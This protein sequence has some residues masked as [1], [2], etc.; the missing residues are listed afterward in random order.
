[1]KQ[2]TKRALAW[3]LAAVMTFA[4]LPALA[5][6]KQT[7]A[8][9]QASG[10]SVKVAVH[11]KATPTPKAKVTVATKQPAASGGVVMVVS[12]WNGGKLNL[13]EYPDINSAC[14]GQY[15][16]GTLVT[17]YGISYGWAHVKV[18]GMWGYMMAI[19][20]ADYS[21]PVKPPKPQSTPDMT[22]AKKYVVS[23]GND[24]KLHLRE[25]ASTRAPSL[26]LFPNG[27]KVKGIDLGN[28]WVLVK[29]NGLYGYMMRKFLVRD[30]GK[31]PTPT[32][33]PKPGGKYQDMQ[34]WTGNS[35]KLHLREAP[36]TLARSLGLYPN[37]T[38][39]K[40]RSVG[41]GWSQVKVAGV[42]GYMM[43][44]YLIPA[45]DDEDDEPTKKPTKK[46]TEEPEKTPKPKPSEK[47]DEKPSEKPDKTPK[48]EKTP[49]P[50]PTPTPKPTKKP[51]ATP[52]P[53]KAKTYQ[54]NGSYVNLRSS[55][56]SMN[57]KNVIAQI[58][59][60]TTVTVL[61]WGKT[62]T[63]VKYKKLTGY[64]ITSYL[65]PKP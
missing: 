65:I 18:N 62:Y 60:G 64:I 4:S 45:Y 22:G 3:G 12:T 33:T 43:S 54:K 59:S 48:L 30:N 47:P 29:V 37:G 28:G 15:A 1:M 11:P 53:M 35:G 52:L 61:E 39:V 49:K 41:N 31:D 23:T 63:K 9:A 25:S 5:A 56:G 17:V 16:N 50:T 42:T 24:G 2:W 51:T 14:L 40:A 19:Y 13:R 57:N 6:E 20:L 58:P 55:I 7:A 46:P 34:V 38:L 10:A 36:T 21:K 44:K 8:A 27:T 26:G 32:P